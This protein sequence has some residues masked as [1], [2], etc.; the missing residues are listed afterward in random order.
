MGAEKT[1]A[2]IGDSLRHVELPSLTIL[3]CFGLVTRLKLER[4]RNVSPKTRRLRQVI[5]PRAYEGA[6]E[7]CFLLQT[8]SSCG[9]IHSNSG[10]V[11]PGFWTADVYS[12]KIF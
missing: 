7:S 11:P 3:H 8:T 1:L 5:P 9:L 12:N 2:S 6:F 4:F 10:T